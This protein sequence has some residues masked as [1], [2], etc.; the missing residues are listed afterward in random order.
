MLYGFSVSVGKI[1]GSGSI[2]VMICSGSRREM[3]FVFR[4]ISDYRII[5]IIWK[6]IIFLGIRYIYISIF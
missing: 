3:F 4:G 2:I 6:E 5:G 1:S